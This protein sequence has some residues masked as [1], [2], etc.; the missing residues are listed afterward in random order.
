MASLGI[1]PTGLLSEE[2]DRTTRDEM[3]RW[4][5]IIANLSD[6]KFE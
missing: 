3:A 5:G 6:I 2:A 4:K 1:E